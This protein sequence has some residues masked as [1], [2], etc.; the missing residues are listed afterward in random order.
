MI[1]CSTT[2]C[3]I[4]TKTWSKR[5]RKRNSRRNDPSLWPA[6]AW[7]ATAWVAWARPPPTRG[8]GTLLS[9]P[10]QGRW[11]A[12]KRACDLQP[13]HSR[14]YSQHRFHGRVGKVAVNRRPSFR[15]LWKKHF[16]GPSCLRRWFCEQQTDIIHEWHQRGTSTNNLSLADAKSL[17]VRELCYQSIILRTK[18]SV[19]SWVLKLIQNNRIKIA[20]QWYFGMLGWNVVVCYSRIKILLFISHGCKVSCV[21]PFFKH[22]F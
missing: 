15:T 14:D 16:K 12:C 1:S 9:T 22:F 21:P 7:A 3:T 17:G 20:P 11:R 6:T 4:W 19:P 10:S 8:S 5:G 18:C 2:F 13:V